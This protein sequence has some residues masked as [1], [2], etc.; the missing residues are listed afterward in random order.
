LLEDSFVVP[1]VAKVNSW[2][3]KKGM[4]KTKVNVSIKLFKEM[5]FDRPNSTHTPPKM[6]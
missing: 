1:G 6:V 2:R 5:V 3:D 4:D